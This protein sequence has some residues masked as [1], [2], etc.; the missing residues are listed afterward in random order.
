M[1]SSLRNSTLHG[2]L[3]I[4]NMYTVGIAALLP[5]TNVKTTFENVCTILFL[6]VEAEAGLPAHRRLQH[7]LRRL[8]RPRPV[9]LV[10]DCK[11]GTVSG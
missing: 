4:H 2:S 1:K 11:D 8:V 10:G 9:S 7:H 6:C 5:N 3:M